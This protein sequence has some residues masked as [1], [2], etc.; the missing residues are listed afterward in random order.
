MEIDLASVLQAV[1][2][3]AVVGV[4]KTLYNVTV[5]VKLHDWRLK[6]LEDK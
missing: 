1:T 5:L 4:A 2:A 3:V 6:Q